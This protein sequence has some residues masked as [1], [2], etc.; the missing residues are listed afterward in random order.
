MPSKIIFGLIFFIVVVGL[1]GFY[2]IVPYNEIDFGFKERNYNF[3]LNDSDKGMQFYPNMR[4]PS[5]TISYS[6]NACPLGKQEDMK[7][8]FEILSKETVLRFYSVSNDA[9]IAVTCDSKNKLEG[10]LFIA[11]EGGPSNITKTSYFNV[12]KKGKILLIK[13]SQCE[14]P[15]IATHE[16]LH[17]LG[18]DHSQNSNNIMYN[19]SQCNQEIGSDIINTINRL[20]STPSYSDLSVENV[21]AAMHGK[22]LNTNFTVMNQG[23]KDSKDSILKIYAD[24]KLV[25]EVDIPELE[26]GYGRKI[27]LINIFV[28]QISTSELKFVIDYNEAE[29][30]KENNEI[31]LNIKE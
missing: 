26:I 17:V 5:S 25:K 4:F 1:L 24:N 7:R 13:E 2:W 6:I 28:L 9:Q 15:G 8:A 16:L 14:N 22:Y 23:L 11:G 18:F 19:V 31:I 10:G 12:I 20:Y 27:S 3:S 29:L 30:Y 21:S